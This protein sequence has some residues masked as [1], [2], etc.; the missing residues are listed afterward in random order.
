MPGRSIGMMNAVMPL[1]L[2]DVDVGAGD[3]L[4]PLG[5]QGARAPHLLAVDDPLVAVARRRGSRGAARSEPAPGSEN[6]WQHSSRAARKRGTNVCALLVGARTHDRRGDQPGRDA[7]GLV[8]RRPR[9]TRARGGRTPGRTRGG[10]RAR[11]RRPAR[12][13]RGSRARPCAWVQRLGPIEE[14]PLL[15]AAERVEHRDAELTLAPHELLVVVGQRTRSACSSSH[16]L[17]SVEERL[18]RGDRL[19]HGVRGPPRR[20]N[21]RRPTVALETHALEAPSQLLMMISPRFI[22]GTSSTPSDFDRRQPGQP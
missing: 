18:E 7:V 8:A 6:S 1:V 16:A 14:G 4:A 13:W 2:R 19:A 12:R 3:Q 11:R 9:R 17:A 21:H 15:V 22:A 5:E 10:S 20:R